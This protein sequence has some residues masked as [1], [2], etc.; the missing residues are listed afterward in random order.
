MTTNADLTIYAQWANPVTQCMEYKR[1]CIEGVSWYARQQTNV[2]NN[3]I[4]S[5]DVYKIR[6]PEESGWPGGKEYIS[7]EQFRVLPANRVD[8]Y[9]T[10]GNGDLF[11]KGVVFDEIDSMEQLFQTH[12]NA[13][14]VLSISDNRQG[15]EPHWRIGGAS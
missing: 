5:A 6:I 11:V 2:V 4:E 15:L 12:E 3:A 7:P 14:K 13:G 1:T 9:W 10:V 8:A